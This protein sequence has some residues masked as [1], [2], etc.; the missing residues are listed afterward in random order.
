MT[1]AETVDLVRQ[2]GRFQPAYLGWQSEHAAKMAAQNGTKPQD[3][4]RAMLASMARTLA[5]VTTDEAAA[6]LAA[7]EAGTLAVPPFGTLALAIR[8]HAMGER[9]ARRA[10]ERYDSEPRYR[11]LA[12]RDT[13]LVEVLNVDFVERFRATFARYQRDGFPPRWVG[14]AYTTWRLACRGPMRHSALCGCDCRMAAVLRRELADFRD[15]T[16]R[17]NGK[18]AG[19]PACGNA[20]YDP[21][22]Q[23][24]ANAGASLAE[25]LAA[26]YAAHEAGSAYEWE[27]TAD[28]Y[29]TRFG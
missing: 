26:W 27:P 28:E 15:G 10:A 5:E 6:A 1:Y 20:E 18:A 19:L 23:P 17:V 11:C 21:Q 25:T 12:C 16:R 4:A 24:L 14:A 2:F 29:E 7:M 3:E 13:G 8:S 22:R 9:S